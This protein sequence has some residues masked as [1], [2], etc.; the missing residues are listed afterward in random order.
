MALAIK[1][2]HAG[3]TYELE[4]DT[5]APAT[6]FKEQIYHKTGVPVDKVKVPVKGGMLK[7]DADLNKLGFK[8]GQT[9]MVIGPAGPLPQAPT[10]PIVFMEDMTDSEL[11]QT[12]KY[13]VG[14]ENLGN[15][16]YMNSTVQ[17][18]RAIPEFQTSLNST[19]TA[20]AQP[21]AQLTKSLRDLYNDMSKTT[22]GFPPFAFLNMLRQFAPQF[23]ERS[24]QTGQYAQQDAQEAWS[25]I[26]QAAKS[27]MGGNVNDGGKFV[28]GW[29]TGRLQKKLSS[30]EAPTEEPK[31]SSENFLELKC[32]ISGTTNYMM[33]GLTEGMTQELEK[34]SES[35]GRD[36]V[37]KEETK[38]DRLPSYLTVNMVR[39]YWRRELAKKTKIMRKV[40]FPFDLDTFDLLSD[41]LKEKVRPVNEKLKEVEKERRER[42][43]TRR[44]IKNKAVE[45]PLPPAPVQNNPTDDPPE[46][47]LVD[48]SV[49]GELPDENSKRQEELATL[50]SLVHPEL[51]QD[52]GANVSGLYELVGI[53]T[54]K[55]ASADG[56]HYVGWTA[57]PQTLPDGS[58]DFDADPDK[59]EWFKFD[60]EKVS[61]IS[62]EKILGLEGGGEDHCAYILLY[63][64]KSLA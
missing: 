13:P 35:L 62:R 30:P 36:A 41:D 19:P 57:S 15:T 34:R 12:A 37:Y 48:S 40:K 26:V 50:M 54:H 4:V 44:K 3:K 5:T 25:Q 53:V 32:N 43:K 27:S 63:K 58:P 29:M 47:M 51:E 1:I 8:A 61:L 49:D 7:D 2:K 38:I 24:R 31:V 59:Q 17:V 16:C 10:K 55:G 6:V 33:Q 42:A 22:E 9:I 20:G 60:D 18:L 14:L 52:K 28:E 64:S 39:F 45:N 23:A 46:P 56:G 11:A 21:D